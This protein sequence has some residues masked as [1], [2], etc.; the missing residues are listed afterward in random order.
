MSEV[1]DFN[2]KSKELEELL[3]SCDCGNCSFKIYEHGDI[4]CAECGRM[5]MGDCELIVAKWTRKQTKENT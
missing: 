2:E 1:I 5:A 4:E 3:W